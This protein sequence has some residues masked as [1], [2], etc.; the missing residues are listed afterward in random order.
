MKPEN[1]YAALL[2]KG[3][4]DHR[5]MEAKT[6][7]PIKKAEDRIMNSIPSLNPSQ[8]RRVTKLLMSNT[9]LLDIIPMIIYREQ[10]LMTG[11]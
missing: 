7:T 9:P 4:G 6:T 11:T 10:K 1:K 2:A 5:E 3:M 8:L